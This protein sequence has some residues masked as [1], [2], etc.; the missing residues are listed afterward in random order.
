[1]FDS[2]IECALPKI[3]GIRAQINTQSLT[4]EKQIT[5]PEKRTE[6]F[7]IGLFSIVY[8]IFF[9]EKFPIILF[10]LFIFA[11]MDCNIVTL[12]KLIIAPPLS[13]ND[14]NGV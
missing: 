11:V 8:W 6:I 10:H 14:V 5:I 12:E 4:L 9:E 13:Q 1:M 2:E 3:A 7:A